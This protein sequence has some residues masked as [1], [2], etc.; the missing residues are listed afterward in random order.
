MTLF[1]KKGRCPHCGHDNTPWVRPAQPQQ[2]DQFLG[3]IVI[4]ETAAAPLFPGP[5]TNVS[6]DLN[7]TGGSDEHLLQDCD[8]GLSQALA[9]KPDAMQRARE[10]AAEIVRGTKVLTDVEIEALAKEH[11][12]SGAGLA[13][14]DGYSTHI[15]SATDIETFGRAVEA[16]VI[17]RL[18]GA[19]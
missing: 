12:T 6:I 9:S 16:A 11:E 4:N 10:A 19:A 2:A 3:N 5:A 8:R 15:F 13:D 1:A 18:G 7:A 14:D 17:A